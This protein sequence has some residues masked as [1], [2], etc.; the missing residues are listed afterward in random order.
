MTMDANTFFSRSVVD[1]VNNLI[2]V[3][4]G[5]TE[6][7]FNYPADDSISIIDPNTDTMY[8]SSTALNTARSSPA[9]INVAQ[10]LYLFGG[11]A[12]D[13]TLID[14]FEVSALLPTQAPTDSV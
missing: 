5:R 11:Y 3:I 6:G 8:L 7:Q 1:E 13:N 14:T 9:V 2:Y 4:G 12:T 10:K